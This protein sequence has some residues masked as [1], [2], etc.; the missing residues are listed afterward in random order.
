MELRRTQREHLRVRRRIPTWKWAQSFAYYLHGR[1]SILGVNRPYDEHV[2][3]DA[4]PHLTDEEI[5]VRA[6][7]SYAHNRDRDALVTACYCSELALRREFKGLGL[8]I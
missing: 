8:R 1:G 4:F 5:H 2:A 3:A 7:H 6:P